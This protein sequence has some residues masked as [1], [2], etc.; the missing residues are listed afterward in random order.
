M[1]AEPKRGAPVASL[2]VDD[3]R[4]ITFP[5]T[6]GRSLGYDPGHVDAF[7]QRCAASLEELTAQLAEQEREIESLKRRVMEPGN[8]DRVLQSLDVLTKAQKTADSTV[9]NA[10]AYSGRVMAE[11]RSMYDDARRQAAAM[12][13]EAHR[14]ATAAADATS[15][16]HGELERQ[17]AYLRT[18]RDVTRVQMEKFLSGLLDHVAEEYGRAQ[19]AAVEAAER[20]TVDRPTASEATESGTNASLVAERP[21]DEPA[22]PARV[23]RS[24]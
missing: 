3:M 1:T 17:T 19:P 16:S 2:T 6:R 10:N 5:E 14:Q 15:A 12:V 24:A 23:S 4:R 13:D 18:L 20:Q 9:A 8:Q 22:I 7:V 11:A 21:N